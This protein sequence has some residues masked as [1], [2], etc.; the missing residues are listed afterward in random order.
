MLSKV[1]CKNATFYCGDE[2]AREFDNAIR[3]VEL[4]RSLFLLGDKGIDQADKGGMN[5]LLLHVWYTMEPDK[6]KVHKVPDEW[7]DPDPNTARG[8]G[9]L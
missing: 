7:V 1:I 2:Y 5:Y 6:F 9:Y 3:E 4:E 8:G